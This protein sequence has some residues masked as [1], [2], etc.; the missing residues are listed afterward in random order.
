[1]ESETLVGTGIGA[2]LVVMRNLSLRL[3]LGVAMNDVG[4]T[5]SG[6]TRLHFVG[7]ILY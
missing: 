1:V 2:E 7:T 4:D 6:E 3:D 5:D